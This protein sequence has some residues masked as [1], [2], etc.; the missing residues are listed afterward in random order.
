MKK[1]FQTLAAFILLISLASCDKFGDIN[2]NPEATER[3]SSSMLATRIILN[4]SNQPMQKAFLQPYFQNKSVVWTEF[5]EGTQYNGGFGGGDISLTPLN[6]AHFMV[7]FAGTEEEASSYSGVMHFARALYFFNQ[8]MTM[9]DVPYSEALQGETDKLYF[10]KYDTQK[11]VFLGIL[12]ELELA[13]DFFA[14]GVRFPGDPLYGGDPA[15]W[16]KLVNSYALNV[17]IQ[18][19]KKEGDADLNIKSRFQTILSSKPIF[20]SNGDN[21]QLIRS[22]KAGQT[23]PFYKVGNNFTIYPIISSEVI[24]RLIDRKDRRLFYY[25]KPSPVKLENGKTA[26]DFDAYVGIDPSLPYDDV[27]SHKNSRDY[28]SFNDRYVEIPEGEPTQKLSYSTLCFI[29]AEAASRGWIAEGEAVNWL[30]K[31][32]QASMEFIRTATPQ[33]LGFNHGM[34]LDDAYIQSYLAERAALFPTTK[35]ARVAEIIEQKYLSTF[36]QQERYAYFDYRRT[37]YPKWKVDPRSNQNSESPTTIPLRWKYPGA[38][39]SYNTAN[40]DAAVERQFG[41]IDDINQKMWI[42]KD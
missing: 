12:K 36:L 16:R 7:S 3:V 18:L 42:L 4:F 29:V 22:D 24:D 33:S 38:E 39:F 37:G 31:G 34:N 5:M 8:T 25:A 21:F 13:D 17:L 1:H 28:S 10:P 27:V 35:D 2:T 26:Q 40:V 20:T 41:G 23:Y 6:D 30:K 32:L 14:K 11:E 15:R 9:G 19:S